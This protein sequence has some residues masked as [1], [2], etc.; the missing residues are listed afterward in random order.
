MRPGPGVRARMDL[1]L[2][3]SGQMSVNGREWAS[4]LNAAPAPIAE[5]SQELG[6]Q[7]TAAVQ[8]LGDGVV[9]PREWSERFSRRPRRGSLAGR[10]RTRQQ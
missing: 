5:G 6:R 10:A 7:I 2:R 8:A 1:W 4:I 9:S 3:E